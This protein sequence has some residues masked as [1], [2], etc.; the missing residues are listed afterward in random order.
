MGKRNMPFLKYVFVC[1]IFFILGCQ[2]TFSDLIEYETIDIKHAKWINA[3]I[4]MGLGV[5]L[6][7]GGAKSLMNGRFDYFMPT[8]RPEIEYQ[9]V[10]NQGNLSIQQSS[11]SSVGEFPIQGKVNVWKILLDSNIP[12]NLNVAMDMG[13]SILNLG[14]LDIRRLHVDMGEGD[15]VINFLGNKIKNRMVTIDGGA[16]NLTFKIPSDIGVKFTVDES[17]GDLD[18]KGFSQEGDSFINNLYKTAK[19]FLDIN[20]YDHQGAVSIE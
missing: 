14:E 3:D 11:R 4:K 9:E 20:I 2:G 1:L 8:K 7:H 18:I 5:L 13:R 6:I 19:I 17:L 10:K 12:I 16:G 15:V